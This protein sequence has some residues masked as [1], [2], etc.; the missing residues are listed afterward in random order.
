MAEALKVQPDLEFIRKIKAAGGDNLKNCYQCATCSVVCKL[1][2]R[3]KP[4]P[5]KEMLWAG[6]GLRDKL[7]SDPDVWLCYQCNDC[8]VNCPRGVKPGDVMAAVRNFSFER[9]AFPAF[10]GRA[11]ANPKALIPLLFIPAVVM[12]VMLY[13]IHGGSLEFMNNPINYSVF[14]PHNYLETFFIFGNVLI[15]ALAAVG[16]FRFWKGLNHSAATGGGPGFISALITTIIEIFFHRRFFDCTANKGR[17]WGHILIF[18]GFVGA[19][20]TT[21]FVVL[22]LLGHKFLNLPPEISHPVFEFPHPVKMLGVLSGIAMIFGW[23]I[24]F[25]RGMS[26]KDESGKR[27]YIDWLFLHMLFLVAL[28]GMLTFV[29]RGF[30]I[31]ALAYATY[32]VHLMVVF[33]LL[34]YMP[35]SKF[36]HML[37]RTLA[38]VWAKSANRGESR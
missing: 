10:M 27:I 7:I 3:D 16:L 34:W 5:R 14:F 26:G 29:F 38:M 20:I 9:F 12:L 8:S 23:L 11:L 4:F 28:T 33:F 37:Y 24:L 21:G 6:W 18:A 19:M 35:Y 31:P 25:I 1:S 15:F 32:F 17:S 22:F 36:A 13:F 30:G 2:P